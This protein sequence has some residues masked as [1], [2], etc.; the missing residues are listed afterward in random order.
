MW[1]LQQKSTGDVSELMNGN[2]M[3]L[4]WHLTDV[5]YS[6]DGRERQ[7]RQMFVMPL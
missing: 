6:L 4:T 7:Q 1:S 3:Q 2:V 5:N